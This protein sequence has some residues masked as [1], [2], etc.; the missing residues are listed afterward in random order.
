MADAHSIAGHN[1]DGVSECLTDIA[2]MAISLK[3]L[4]LDVMNG[5]DPGK[6][7]AAIEALAEK[8]GYLADRALRDL[9]KPGV[10]GSFDEW[11]RCLSKRDHSRD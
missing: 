11:L 4:A 6:C 10:C 7:G 3:K 5:G 9:G 8:S 1:P 2:T